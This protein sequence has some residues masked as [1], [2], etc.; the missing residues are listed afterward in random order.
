[1]D[2]EFRK[3]NGITLYIYKIHSNKYELEVLPEI[4]NSKSRFYTLSKEIEKIEDAVEN[5][6]IYFKDKTFMQ[7]S[8]YY[9]FTF[10]ADI[11]DNQNNQLDF[12]AYHEFS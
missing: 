6:Y 3:Q 1:M 7:I 10:A 9:T 5:V 2:L 12:F 4:K 8:F 11:Y